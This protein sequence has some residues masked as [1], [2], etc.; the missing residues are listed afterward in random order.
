M[1]RKRLPAQERK[2]QILKSATRVF[3]RSNYRAARVADIA[4]EAG[5]S[6]AA[7]YKYFPSKKA[8]YLDILRHISRRVITVWQ[9]EVDKEQDALE[10]LRNMGM[11]YFTRMIE[12]PDE[13]K[14]QFQ[15]ISEVA[16]EDIAAQLRRDHENYL[17]FFKQILNKGIDQGRVRPDLNV[18][19]VAGIYDALGVML[20]LA[21]LL[22]FDQILS[23]KTTQGILDHLGDSIKS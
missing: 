15:A 6:E 2:K 10:A 18:Q 17:K 13:V 14:V 9:E 22:S 11:T 3:A 7:L 19:A 21:K 1:A 12:H 4:A 20:N 23:D 16:D 5:V 8:I